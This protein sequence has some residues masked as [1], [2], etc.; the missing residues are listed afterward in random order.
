MRTSAGHSAY[1]IRRKTEIRKK[2]NVDKPVEE[3][4]AYEGEKTERHA[5]R[6]VEDR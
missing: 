4:I 2:L 5:D 1:R 3:I 6:M